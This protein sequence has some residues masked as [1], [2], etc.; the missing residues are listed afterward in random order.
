MHP[1]FGLKIVQITAISCECLMKSVEYRSLTSFLPVIR[2]MAQNNQYT[3]M[4]SSLIT[5][6]QQ[7]VNVLQHVLNKPVAFS[8]NQ[9]GF[10]IMDEV[11]NIK[12]M[13]LS[14]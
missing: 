8:S 2:E 9:F 14:L 11:S 5:G 10:N 1:H 12:R 13:I 3:F 4:Y 6:N 7:L